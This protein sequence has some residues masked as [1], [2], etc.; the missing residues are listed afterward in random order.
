MPWWT[1]RRTKSKRSKQPLFKKSGAKIFLESGPG[2]LDG[3]RPRP[4]F[5]K[6]FLLRA[7]RPGFS[8]EKEVLACCFSR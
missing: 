6:V 3:K 4:R 2:A 1:K 7:E 8:S 5:I